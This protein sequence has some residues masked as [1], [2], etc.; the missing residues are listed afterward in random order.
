MQVRYTLLLYLSI[1]LLA[2]TSFSQQQLTPYTVGMIWYDKGE[3]SKAI[4]FFDRA[5]EMN[6]EDNTAYFRRC[7]S[8]YYLGN[9]QNALQDLEN[10]FDLEMIDNRYFFMKGQFY[11]KL[12][13]SSLAAYYL[14]LAIASEPERLYYYTY[15]SAFNMEMGNYG[16][17]LRDYDVIIAADPYNYSAYFGRG[18]AKFNLKMKTD[19]CLDWLYGCDK[20]ES[21]QRYFFYKYTD[22]DLRGL[23]V[24]PV[25]K[26]ELIKPEFLFENDTSLSY[27][28]T[29]N[30]VYPDKAILSKKQGTVL[31]KFT[32]TTE[33]NLDDIRILFSPSPDFESEMIQVIRE[34]GSF[35]ITP[36]MKNGKPVDYTYILPVTFRLKDTLILKSDLLDTLNSMLN[37]EKYSEASIVAGQALSF[38]PFMIEVFHSYKLALEKSDRKC[39]FCSFSWF[40]DLV[41][42]DGEIM[43]EVCF[44]AEKIVLYYNDIWEITDPETSSYIRIGKW[45]ERNNFITGPF[46]DYRSDGSICTEGGYHEKKK[47]GSFRFFFPDG[48]VSCEFNYYND[49]LKDTCR[50]YHPDGTL[51]HSIRIDGERFHVLEYRDSSGID[52][53]HDGTGEWKFSVM[54]YRNTD[55][56]TIQGIMS[57]HQ[58]DGVWYYLRNNSVLVEEK[59]TKGTINSSFYFDNNAKSRSYVSLLNSWMLVP[60]SLVRSEKLMID[61]DAKLEYY[62]FIGRTSRVIGGTPDIKL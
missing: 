60:F 3:Y 52:L 32:I 21:C 26:V 55:T 18:L 39:E 15:R 16:K 28:L 43:D 36:A 24:K 48:N 44:M 20:N 6:P 33:S 37:K 5:I 57:N 53:L 40:D 42:Q 25:Q 54:D 9:Y 13:Q 19:A 22:L 45:E 23:N 1:S 46:T 31:I 2:S 14:D 51:K 61:P 47:Y 11:D 58:K 35:W 10:T 30:L 41:L 17:A 34:S 8:F 62:P 7:Y 49:Q 59:Y 12:K 4:P 50:F 29:N 56:L 38:N 27:Y